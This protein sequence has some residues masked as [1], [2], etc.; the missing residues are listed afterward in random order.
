MVT[1]FCTAGRSAVSVM[2]L[3]KTMVSPLL[4]LLMQ[5]VR[6]PV[7]LALQFAACAEVPASSAVPA[8][9]VAQSSVLRRVLGTHRCMKAPT[10]RGRPH[11]RVPNEDDF[12]RPPGQLR[13]AARPNFAVRCVFRAT[14]LRHDGRLLT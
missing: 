13:A 10:P 2:L 5:V 4:A 14:R 11:Y 7:S 9:A 3:L 8:S 12:S 6:V 1:F